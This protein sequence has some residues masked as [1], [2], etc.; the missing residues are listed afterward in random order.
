ME[1]EKYIVWLS[2]VSKEDVKIAGGK[3]ANLGEMF[4]SGFP[5]PQAFIIT[6][7]AFH[8]F[9]KQTNIEQQIKD[10]ISKIDSDDTKALEEKSREIREMIINKEMPEDLKE[11]I[12]ESYDNFNIDLKELENS[13]DAL[14]IMKSARE[15]VFVSVRSSATAEDLGSAS[16]AGQQESFINIKGNEELIKAVK[17][18]FASIFT[19]RSIYYRKKKGFDQIVGIAVIVQK[20]VNSDKSGV[21]FS[22]NPI[23][24]EDNILIEAVFGQGEG[25]VSGKIKPDILITDVNVSQYDAIIFIGGYGASIYFSNETALEIA[26]NAYQHDKIVGAICIA[27]CILAYSGI[28]NGKNAT[29]YPTEEYIDIIESN[30]ANFINAPVVKDGKI[31]TARNPSAANDFAKAIINALS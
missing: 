20:M 21:I 26:K 19:A 28:L 12:I 11:E 5:V 31:I 14:A 3:G 8:Y 13:P 16:F 24:H 30:G 25:I 23:T 15:P 7:K 2:E 6:T 18:V 4:N 29:V 17:K 9:L 27:P 22:V 1:K 10:I